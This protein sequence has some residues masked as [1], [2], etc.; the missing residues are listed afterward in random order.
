[1]RGMFG[2]SELHKRSASGVKLTHAG[3]MVANYAR[4]VVLGYESLRSD[5]D[6]IRGRRR[7]IKADLFQVRRRIWNALGAVD[8]M[9]NS[10]AAVKPTSHGRVL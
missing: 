6:D 7:N 2:I 4:S 9:E 8:N 1:M 5:L 3:K 10:H